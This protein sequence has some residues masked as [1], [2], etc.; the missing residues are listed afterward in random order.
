MKI[1][2]VGYGKMGRSVEKIARDRGHVIVIVQTDD[3]L[4]SKL[5]GV[6]SA[7]EFT[8]PEAAYN[9]ISTAL[10]QRV[11]VVCGTTGWTDRMQEIIQICNKNNTGFLYAS[12]FSIGVNIT[13]EINRRLALYMNRYPEYNCAI[14]EIHHTQKKD[15]PSGT[16]ISLAQQIVESTDKYIDWKL[17]EASNNE[18]PIDAKRIEDVI[19]THT[20]TYKGDI[21]TIS[22]KHE[23]HNRTGFALGAVVAAEW[24]QGKQG[25]YTMRD[26]LFNNETD[27]A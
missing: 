13:F 11:P 25:F 3:D 8:T 4:A 18:I 22:I 10:N 20:V 16:A 5:N 19:G 12:N 26:V 23:A 2:I 24:L 7:I 9:N 1:A 27:N 6:D 21:D 14:E 17:G 15:A